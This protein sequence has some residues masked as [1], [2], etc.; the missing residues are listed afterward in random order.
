MTLPLPLPGTDIL[1]FDPTMAGD[2]SFDSSGT[3][4]IGSGEMQSSDSGIGSIISSIGNTV[5]GGIALAGGK[6]VTTGSLVTVPGSQTPPSGTSAVVASS[7]GK[8]VSIGILL[9]AAFGLLFFLTRKHG[10]E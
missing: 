5:L 10:G 1:P 4:G 3:P 9:V 7:I 8:D 6:N 2:P